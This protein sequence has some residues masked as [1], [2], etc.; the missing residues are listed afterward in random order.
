MEG[1]R[2][3]RRLC[4]APPPPDIAHLPAC[5]L[6]C[7]PMPDCLWTHSALNQSMHHVYLGW[8][9]SSK[10]PSSPLFSPT[11]T[12]GANSLQSAPYSRPTDSSSLTF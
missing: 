5:R 10:E 7:S 11:L 6:A 2:G 4:T 8:V 9:P 12:N 1:R 3:R